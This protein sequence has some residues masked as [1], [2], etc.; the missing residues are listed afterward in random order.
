MSALAHW[1]LLPRFGR[2]SKDKNI[3][4]CTKKCDMNFL[5]VFSGYSNEDAMI[6]RDKNWTSIVALLSQ[7]QKRTFF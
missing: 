4:F 3:I 7:R 6:E 1:Q 5:T 2:N